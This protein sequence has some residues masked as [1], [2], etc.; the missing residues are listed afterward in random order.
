M[1]PSPWTLVLYLLLTLALVGMIDWVAVRV[2]K[3]RRR[4]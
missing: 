2:S 4:R 1:T 3:W